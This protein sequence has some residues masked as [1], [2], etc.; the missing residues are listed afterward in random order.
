M[1][2]Q[3]NKRRPCAD[4]LAYTVSTDA[5]KKLVID[6]GAGVKGVSSTL[7]TAVNMTN[8]LVFGEVVQYAINSISGQGFTG[9]YGLRGKYRM[10]V[11]LEGLPLRRAD[12][13]ALPN[14]SVVVP[15]VLTESGGVAASKTISGPGL[16]G[17][18]TLTD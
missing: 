13:S 5:K 17:Y 18:V 1:Q 9:I 3:M 4:A 7:S 12:G 2:M 6:F 8:G 15:T 14:L 10:T 16:V 11:V